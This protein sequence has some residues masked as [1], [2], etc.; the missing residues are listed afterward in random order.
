LR[1][2]GLRFVWAGRFNFYCQIAGKES[3][4]HIR[5]VDYKNYIIITILI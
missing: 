1:S 2:W 4:L 5:F 3:K